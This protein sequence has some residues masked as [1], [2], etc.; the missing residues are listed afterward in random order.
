VADS[1]GLSET[2]K[3]LITKARRASQLR[4]ESCLREDEGSWSPEDSLDPSDAPEA[5]LE[6]D[7]ERAEV[8]SRMKHL[9]DRERQ[10]LILRFGLSGEDPLT[11]KEIGRRL[12]VTRE[13]V[14]KI[15]LKAVS[16]LENHSSSLTTLELTQPA[17]RARTTPRPR[18]RPVATP[19]DSTGTAG[20]AATA[21]TEAVAPAIPTKRTRRAS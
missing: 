15:E 16:R 12:G 13:W 1:L 8:L 10:V 21:T 9:D 14:R 2:Q 11:L 4:L 20:L 5:S 6:L 17:R 18:R 7:E 19:V 3:D